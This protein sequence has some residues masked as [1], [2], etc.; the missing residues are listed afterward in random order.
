MG[1]TFDDKINE[2]NDYIA[3]RKAKWR[4]ESVSGLTFD[5][6][7][8][9]LRIHIFKKWYLWD[10]TRPFGN[11]INRVITHQM[12]N[13]I[14]NYYGNLA[15]PCN[16]DPK[17]CAHNQGGNLC[18]W[19]PSGIKCSECPLYDKWEKTKKHGYNILLADSTDREDYVEVSAGHNYDMQNGLDNLNK[20][21]ENLLTLEEFFVYDNLFI[22]GKN[23]KAV[24]I[25][26]KE[27]FGAPKN[28]LL[29][30]KQIIVK[31]KDILKENNVFYEEG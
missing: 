12:T 8:Q 14:R 3:K 28:I 13:L 30:K 16:S 27:R 29:M 15:P 23:I 26:F 11:W 17:P 5:D 7:S 2:I 24:Q 19:T 25:L 20:L 10:Q 22:K 31:V 1:Y 4:L 18:G 21:L 9:I 6:V